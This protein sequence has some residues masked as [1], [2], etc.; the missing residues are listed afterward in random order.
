[1]KLAGPV[2]KGERQGRKV[3]AIAASSKFSE[4]FSEFDA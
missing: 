2:D 1:M 4:S 3:K